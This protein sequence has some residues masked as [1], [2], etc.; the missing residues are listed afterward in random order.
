MKKIGVFLISSL[1]FAVGILF[2]GC[3]SDP[4]S[5]LKAAIVKTNALKSYE[6]TVELSGFEDGELQLHT[7]ADISLNFKTKTGIVRDGN[8]ANYIYGDYMYD[9][10]YGSTRFNWDD[11]T[12]PSSGGGV[13]IANIE[14]SEQK[15]TYNKLDNNKASYR[16][17]VDSVTANAVIKDEVFD[18]ASFSNFLI[19]FTVDTVSGYWTKL[20]ASADFYAEDFGEHNA[21]IDIALTLIPKGDDYSIFVPLSI[22]NSIILDSY[23]TYDYSYSYLFNYWVNG[24][25][26]AVSEPSTKGAAYIS[27]SHIAYYNLGTF[28]K[29]VFDKKTNVLAVMLADSVMLIN[30]DTFASINVLPYIGISDISCDNGVMAVCC[31][32]RGILDIYD[33]ASQMRIT[34]FTTGTDYYY[35]E[36][37]YIAVLDGDCILWSDVDQWCD[38]TMWNYKTNVTKVVNKAGSLYQ[39]EIVLDKAA[40]K[41]FA[42]ETSLSSCDIYLFDSQTGNQVDFYPLEASYER[43]SAYHDGKHL[44]TEHFSFDSNL[45]IISA[46]HLTQKYG[47][48]SGF[49]SVATILNDNNLSIVRGFTGTDNQIAVYDKA[50]DKYFFLEKGYA[51][52]AVKIAADKYLLTDAG[53]SFCAVINISDRTPLAENANEPNL[54]V[55][56]SN[57]GKISKAVLSNT[58]DTGIVCGDNIY[59]LRPSAKA[60]EIF[61][62]NTL[63]PVKTL[64]F[65]LIP[66]SIDAHEG[67]LV[68][69]MGYGNQLYIYDI[70]D[71]SYTIIYSNVPIFETVIYSNMIYFCDNN[72]HIDVYSYNISTGKTNEIM[73]MYAP[74]LT[75]DKR[76]GTLYAAEN[77]GSGLELLKFYDGVTE[78]IVG[79]DYVS[80]ATRFDGRYLHSY[81]AI[82]DPDT[83]IAF[84][85]DKY[86]S[87]YPS[88]VYPKIEGVSYFDNTFS[89]FVV[90]KESKEYTVLFNT[91]KKKL[92]AEFEGSYYAALSVGGDLYLFGNKKDTIYKYAL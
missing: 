10:W 35:D 73:H 46:G 17:E 36:Q 89:V 28:K 83:N 38:L 8:R 55:S 65:T 34:G 63:Q 29:V 91:V 66:V 53:S 32:S 3:N 33:I 54:G 76:N 90:I 48:L 4:I 21:H 42:V 40:H 24:W 50:V 74:K 80:T 2:T 67:R 1:F 19:E 72:Q 82:F 11:F 77:S 86:M 45:N 9:E 16:I 87:L 81:G 43:R 14:I 47:K 27:N 85:E 71:W 56:V 39:P 13:S 58:Y 75:V 49:T 57:I 12:D 61:D 88:A 26:A 20:V 68:I 52:R 31:G 79:I 70:N 25:Q 69:G 84:T 37:P 78:R 30:A 62:R 92:L 23:R 7:K 41:V 6:M 60:V 51:S 22:Q 44:H 64:C 15:I 5:K 59:L 18:D